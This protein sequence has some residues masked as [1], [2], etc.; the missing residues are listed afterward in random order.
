MA[1]PQPT[2]PDAYGASPR[3]IPG[4][5]PAEPEERL[6]HRLLGDV[7][8]IVI[9]LLDIARD[10]FPKEFPRLLAV[11][12]VELAVADREFVRVASSFTP[13]LVA[14]AQKPP[15]CGTYFSGFAWKAAWSSLAANS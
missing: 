7:G 11:V 1:A 12:D 14:K 2:A 6:T 4:E 15:Y 5:T 8:P 10:V 13:L 3:L 9:G